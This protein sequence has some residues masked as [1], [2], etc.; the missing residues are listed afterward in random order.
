ME[1]DMSFK[2]TFVATLPV[3][4]SSADPIQARRNALLARLK[5]QKALANDPSYRR[6]FKIRTKDETGKI[7]FETGTSTIRQSWRDNVF[8]MRIGNAKLLELAKG[9]PGIA[10]KSKEE[11][12]QAID[13]VAAEVAKGTYDKQLEEAAMKSRAR[14]QKNK[15]AKAAA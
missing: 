15:K 2:P 4:T 8:F 11:L 9:Q 12:V 6:T 10:F 14:L 7:A 5:D 3:S 1:D 13:W